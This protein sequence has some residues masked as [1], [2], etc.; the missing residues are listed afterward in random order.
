MDG[1][2]EPM[3]IPQ[4][5]PVATELRLAV[6]GGDL[7]TAARLLAGH[8]GLARARF[9]GRDEGTGTSLHMVSDWPGYFHNGAEMV[10]LSIST[11][12]SGRLA[13]EGSAGWPSTCWRAAPTSTPRLTM[14]PGRR[15]AHSFLATSGPVMRRSS[16]NVAA[17]MPRERAIPAAMSR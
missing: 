11:R 14:P 15:A 17:M 12:R 13:A 6:H 1:T 5:D 2:P 7:E 4:H 16:G 3:R 10:R 8:P 9:V